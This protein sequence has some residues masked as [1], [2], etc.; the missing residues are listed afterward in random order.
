MMR[1]QVTSWSTL[2]K[3]LVTTDGKFQKKT[4]GIRKSHVPDESGRIIRVELSN[5]AIGS[6]SRQEHRELVATEKDTKIGNPLGAGLNTDHK[7]VVFQGVLLT[8]N[9][10]S[11]VTDVGCGQD[12][13]LDIQLRTHHAPSSHVRRVRGSR[14]FRL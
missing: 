10:D 11:F 5:V 7:T 2:K 1:E 13:T 12:T 6:Q 9:S 4:L 3:H 14:L 8:G